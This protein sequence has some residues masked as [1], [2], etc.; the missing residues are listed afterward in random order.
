MIRVVVAEDSPTARALIVAMLCSDPAIVVAGEA[1][2]GVE[3]VEMTKRLRPNVVLMDIAMPKL[4]G[5]EATRRIMTEAPTPVV[6]VSATLDPADVEDSMNALR[7]GAVAVL[8]KPAG[9][10]SARF[11]KESRQF[12]RTVKLMAGVRVVRHH[13]IGAPKPSPSLPMQAGPRGAPVGVVAIA[14]STGGP[15]ALQTVLA[16]I[17]SQFSAPILVVQHIS[18]GFV[19]GFAEWL[20]STL[21]LR[22]EV[23]RHGTQLAASTVYIAPDDLHLGVDRSSRI[24]LSGQ[25]PI[26]GFRPSA[27]FLF[28]TVAQAFGRSAV[29]VVLTGM[30]QDGVE[31]LRYVREHAGRIIAQDEASSVVFGMPGAAVA[32]G[33]AD[34]VLS[35][36]EIAPRLSALAR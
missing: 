10:A 27:N 33:L 7:A 35:L 23:A 22:V 26:H 24:I 30:G 1:S 12:L 17:S 20:D 16:G 15:A 19:A 13:R 34:S 29:A 14:A 8:A 6:I 32:A 11:E 5:L 2:D 31:G 25:E 18:P 3:A 4:D 36:G 28:Q 9:P 21:P